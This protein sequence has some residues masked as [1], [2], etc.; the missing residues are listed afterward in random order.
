MPAVKRIGGY[1]AS[2]ALLAYVA[3]IA[4]Y[5]IANWPWT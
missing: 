1:A 4:T 3:W 2:L 5:A